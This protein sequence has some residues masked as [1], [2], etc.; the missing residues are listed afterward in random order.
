MNELTRDFEQNWHELVETGISEIEKNDLF[1]LQDVNGNEC[2]CTLEEFKTDIAKLQSEK[3]TIAVCGAVKAG[4]STF[5]NSLLFGKAV[6]PAFSTPMTAKLNFIEYSPDQD[7][8]EVNYYSNEEWKR[9]RDTLDEDNLNQLD[10]RIEKCQMDFGVSEDEYIGSSPVTI[11]DLS[12]LEEYVSDPKAG[13]GKYTPFVKDVHIRIHSPQVEKLCIVDTPGLNDP[14]TINSDE[15][16]KWIRNAHAVIFLL[17]P[18]GYEKSDKD[19]VDKN[20]VTT[21]PEN[22]LWIINKIDDLGDM[23]KLES[24]KN[25]MRELGRS[26]EFK[27]KN[28]F[29]DREKI[30]GYSALISMLRRMQNDGE[31]L[32]EEQEEMLDLMPD[33]FNPDPD[34]V[35]GSVS[36]RLYENIGEKR[37]AAGVAK[38]KDV[39]SKKSAK[40]EADFDEAVRKLKNV[41]SDVSKLHEDIAKIQS[42]ARKLKSKLE[43][44]QR[45]YLH[46]SR[47]IMAEKLTA[48]AKKEIESFHNRILGE[49]NAAASTAQLIL[50]GQSFQRQMYNLFGSTGKFILYSDECQEELGKPLKGMCKDIR[51]EFEENGIDNR[52]IDFSPLDDMTGGSFNIG[53]LA[54]ELQA[55]LE[56]MLP[57]NFLSDLFTGKATKRALCA[58]ALGN[59]INK[60]L[61]Q[62]DEIVEEFRVKTVN[63]VN[64]GFTAFND[65]IKKSCMEKEAN[66]GRDPE[67]LKKEESEW[68]Q[69]KQFA[70]KL[71]ERVDQMW[72]A[73]E[74]KLPLNLRSRTNG[75]K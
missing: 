34:D 33:D 74:R 18:K 28:L 69:K 11:N 47:K 60:T 14:N 46:N 75:V 42:V 51:R 67:E 21:Q 63:C 13:K 39:F 68:E 10:E 40:A 12:A 41:Q 26:P 70:E 8:F 65:K 24:V 20:L 62:L 56:S 58:S 59:A 3:F 53:E 55:D 22:R 72:A 61:E 9:L 64:S 49:I 19:F 37:I 48:R 31:E 16:I 44:F 32:D 36:A 27:A 52:D 23:Q 43:I 50:C 1:P 2:V 38:V 6:L 17:R 5:L 29:G 54:G 45:D 30:C 57:S 25:Y 15:T 71:K 66:I 73:Y 4:K 35:P 7:H